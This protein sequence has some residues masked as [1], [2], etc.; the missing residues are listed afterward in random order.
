MTKTL[1]IV[2]GLLCAVITAAGIMHY[3]HPCHPKFQGISYR[4][5]YFEEITRSG[6]TISE[7]RELLKDENPGMREAAKQVLKGLGVSAEEI[8]EAKKK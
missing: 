3:K 5:P 7:I 6:K 4:G 1:L 8:E 2:I